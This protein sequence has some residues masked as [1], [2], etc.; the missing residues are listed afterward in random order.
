MLRTTAIRGSG[1]IL[2]EAFLRRG[3]GK[4]RNKFEQERS[5]EGRVVNSHDRS[6]HSGHYLDAEAPR[7]GAARE[8]KNSMPCC[9]MPPRNEHEGNKSSS[10]F[11]HKSCPPPLAP[12]LTAAA[13]G[14]SEIDWPMTP[15]AFFLWDTQIQYTLINSRILKFD[16]LNL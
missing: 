4:T 2:L 1:T 7:L 15:I 6:M 3:C 5:W 12:H 16:S 10:F 11:L 9:Y 14:S 8:V 13:T